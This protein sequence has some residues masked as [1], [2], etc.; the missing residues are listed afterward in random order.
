MTRLR[1]VTVLRVAALLVLAAGPLVSSLAVL[2]NNEHMYVAAGALVRDGQALY[3]DFAFLQTPYLP[4]LYAGLF[5]LTGGTHLLLAGK[6]LSWA[7][8][9]WTA[10]LARGLARRATGGWLPDAVVALVLL[11]ALLTRAAEEAANYL[12]P[13]ALSLL[14]VGLMLDAAEGARPRGARA[15]AAGLALGAA[16]GFKLYYLA[17]VPP[18]LLTACVHPRGTPAARRLGRG[19]PQPLRRPAG[20]A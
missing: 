18:F 2:H 9:L 5:T 17:A 12:P 1:P 4:W 10:W 7:S 11:E 6:L 8:L 13:V 3:R 14:A 20:P 16:V 15:F 19:L